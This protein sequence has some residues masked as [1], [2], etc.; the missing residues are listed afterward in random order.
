[1]PDFPDPVT[2]AQGIS[3]AGSVNAGGNICAGVKVTGKN[4]AIGTPNGYGEYPLASYDEGR[5]LETTLII[6]KAGT[7][8]QN[9]VPYCIGAEFYHAVNLHAVSGEIFNAGFL[10]ETA[11]TASTVNPPYHVVDDNVGTFGSLVYSGGPLPALAGGMIV[12]ASQNHSSGNL[13]TRLLFAFTPDGS[14]E[15]E[16]G[17]CLDGT[18]GVKTFAVTYDFRHLGANVGFYNRPAV[19]RGQYN[20]NQFTNTE[21]RLAELIRLLHE[22]GLIKDLSRQEKD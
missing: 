14:D 19:P 5:M 12:Q 21:D 6:N 20:A 1:M 16:V 7:G 11:N 10:T 9:T 8:G 2:T 18:D 15:A 4:L 22:T 17:A 3:A 13:G